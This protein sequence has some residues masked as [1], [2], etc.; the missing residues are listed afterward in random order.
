M[1]PA[2]VL[3]MVFFNSQISD[4]LSGRM[5]FD[6]HLKTPVSHFYVGKDAV[7]HLLM[8]IDILLLY[9]C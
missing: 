6:I 4:C 7:E 9:F 5:V 1:K 8:M 3:L 2:D